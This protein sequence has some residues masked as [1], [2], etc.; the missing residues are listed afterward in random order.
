MKNISDAETESKNIENTEESEVEFSQ[1][2]W[3]ESYIDLNTNLQNAA[4][5]KFEKDLFKLMVNKIFGKTMENVD[6]R[7]SIIKLSS[8]WENKNGTLGAR[9]LIAISHFKSCSVF[10]ENLVTVQLEKLKF[11]YD[12]PL[13]A[14]FSILDIS[15][16]II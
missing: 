16:T 7:Q 5:N 10:D 13:Y 4:K 14:G 15:K 11:V 12:K 8:C 2:A 9:T 6:K 3:L 1:S